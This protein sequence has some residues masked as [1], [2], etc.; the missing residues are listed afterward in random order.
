MSFIDKLICRSRQNHIPNEV[1]E[2][3]KS[4]EGHV[5]SRSSHRSSDA[6]YNKPFYPADSDA[7]SLDQ[8]VKEMYDK[9]TAAGMAGS[10]YSPLL[11]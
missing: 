1:S 6:D 8:A 5:S 3:S 11:V 2:K 7:Q 4:L 10:I 9:R